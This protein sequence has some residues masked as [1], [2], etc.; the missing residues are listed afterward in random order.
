MNKQLIDDLANDL[1]PCSPCCPYSMV[2]KLMIVALTGGF[3]LLATIGLRPD[4]LQSLSS[5]VPFWKSGIFLIVGVGAT[6][7]LCRLGLPG[8]GTG[9]VGPAL[10]LLGLSGLI[11][12]G[13]GAVAFSEHMDQLINAVNLGGRG[14]CLVSIT[15]LGI[16]LMAAGAFV[17][18]GMAYTRPNLAGWLL[19]TGSAAFA[20]AAYAWHCIND[21][22]F[23]VAAWYTI[24]VVLLG[25]L[26][27][28]LG[29]RLFRL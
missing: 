17:L 12:F 14:F 20:A 5:V 21:Q 29:R 11:G 2:A 9:I 22:P 18:R 7:T 15:G 16:T 24:P 27:L 19:G 26:G 28:G 8:R 6:L 25:L 10:M 4:L 23:Y 3:V 13:L 1:K